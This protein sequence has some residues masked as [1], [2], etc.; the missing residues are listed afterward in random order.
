MNS[1]AVLNTNRN[2]LENY[3]MERERRQVEKD[4]INN[5]KME[6]AELKEMVQTVIGKQDG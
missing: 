3:K 6:L 4:D 5:I 2:A 1:K